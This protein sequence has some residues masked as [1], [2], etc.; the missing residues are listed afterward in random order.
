MQASSDTCH[1]LHLFILLHTN[2]S[3]T[4]PSPPHSPTL[5]SYFEFYNQGN[6]TEMVSQDRGKAH[7]LNHLHAKRQ[8]KEFLPLAII[9]V[10][11]AL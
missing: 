4:Q 10:T 1:F 3:T 9:T 5:P 6:S 2:Q 11:V 8:I 7:S